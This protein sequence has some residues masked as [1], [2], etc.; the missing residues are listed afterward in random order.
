MIWPATRTLMRSASETNLHVVLD[1]D[2][3]RSNRFRLLEQFAVI[4][5]P[6]LRPMPAIGSSSNSNCGFWAM[7]MASSSYRASPCDRSRASV[8]ARALRP[9]PRPPRGPVPAEPDRDAHLRQKRKEWPSRACTASAAWSSAE[10]SGNER[11]DLERA[12]NAG[13]G[14]RCAGSW[15]DIGAVQHNRSGVGPQEPAVRNEVVV[16]GAVR[17]DDRVTLAPFDFHRQIVGARRP[18]KLFISD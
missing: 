10:K 6:S 1:Q 13:A 7:A 4:T 5:A 17:P 3:R 15:C 11:G 2:D 14:R 9:P 16:A 18:P 8:S 12:R